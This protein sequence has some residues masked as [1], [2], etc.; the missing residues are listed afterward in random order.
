M[1]IS[2]INNKQLTANEKSFA[3]QPIYCTKFLPPEIIHLF[4]CKYVVKLGKITYS[5]FQVN[6]Y[7]PDSQMNKAGLT[8]IFYYHQNIII[9]VCSFQKKSN[10]SLDL[11]RKL[12][13]KYRISISRLHTNVVMDLV[14][15]NSAWT[16]L[17]RFINNKGL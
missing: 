2:Y 16:F 5:Y 14:S 4:L 11:F 13:L 8:S 1:Y 12:I 17:F 3:V 10:H 6:K 7:P 9:F 15:S